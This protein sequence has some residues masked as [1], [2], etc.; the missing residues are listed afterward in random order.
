[1]SSRSRLL[2]QVTSSHQTEEPDHSVHWDGG[3]IPNQ[4]SHLELS[5]SLYTTE[6]KHFSKTCIP[7]ACEAP[8]RFTAHP[9][10]Q[11]K[12]QSCLEELEILKKQ[13][14]SFQPK[15]TD[16]TGFHKKKKKQH[17]KTPK[18]P[19]TTLLR[20]VNKGMKANCM[21]KKR[22]LCCGSK[23]FQAGSDPCKRSG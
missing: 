4:G 1:L 20:R 9:G 12:M 6:F 17:K 7:H 18:N 13:K 3:W 19:N 14:H 23:N 8:P 21:V 15:L 11:T 16:V 5:T 2:P 22:L 10:P